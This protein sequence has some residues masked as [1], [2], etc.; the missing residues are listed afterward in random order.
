MSL[1]ERRASPSGSGGE[2]RA[3]CGRAQIAEG[4]VGTLGVVP[5]DPGGDRPLRRGEVREAVHP[6]ALLLERPEPPLDEAVLFGSIGG[7]VFL[8]EAILPA[9][10]TEAL[11]LE[12]EAVGT[13]K[14]TIARG[15][16][17]I[18]EA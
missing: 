2:R 15:P 4:L 11:A 8:R 7:D 14:V 17:A 6:D 12:D 3:E 16:C 18:L 13:V 1:G 5:G 10:G 9:G